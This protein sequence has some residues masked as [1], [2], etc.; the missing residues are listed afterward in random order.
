MVKLGIWLV[1]HL[2]NYISK[3][4]YMLN[5]LKLSMV[6]FSYYYA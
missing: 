5:M 2:K 3:L 4:M 6:V 1:T